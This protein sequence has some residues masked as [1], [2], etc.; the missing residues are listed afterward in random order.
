V[1]FYAFLKLL[2]LIEHDGGCGTIEVEAIN[3]EVCVG[4]WNNIGS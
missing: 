2:A 1:T 4:A 3:A